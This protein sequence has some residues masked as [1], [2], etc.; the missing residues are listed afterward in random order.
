MDLTLD[1]EDYKLNIRAAGVIIHNNKILA[2]RNL[3]KDHYCIP[4]G[5]VEIGE[6]SEETIKR[7]IQEE[8]GKQIEITGYVATIENFFE[9]NESKYHEIYFLHEI[10]F[11]NEEDKKINCTM[12]NTEGKEYLQYEW[13]DLDR[14]EEYNILPNCL[15]KVLKSR[16]FP[17]HVVNDDFKQMQK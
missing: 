9:M 10:E 4:G 13:L 6:N 7:E 14:I 12:H 11:T 8:L 2:H 1:V 15:K 16:S 3:N 5:R 17:M